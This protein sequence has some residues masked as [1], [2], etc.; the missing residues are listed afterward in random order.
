MNKIYVVFLVLLITTALKAQP[1]IDSITTD[2][3]K[4]ELLV[5]GKFHSQLPT[6][7]YVDSVALKINFYSD[8]LYK[9]QI[10][11]MGKGS[12]G[13]VWVT[14]QEKSSN[15][16]LLTFWH[17]YVKTSFNHSYSDGGYEGW[18]VED[19]VHFRMDVATPHLGRYTIQLTKLSTLH[20]FADGQN[21]IHGYFYNG[22]RYDRRGPLIGYLVYDPGNIFYFYD[23][24]SVKP[25]AADLHLDND[26]QILSV[27][28][29]CWGSSDCAIWTQIA[30]VDFPPSILDVQSKTYSHKDFSPV[31]YFDQNTLQSDVIVNAASSMKVEIELTDVIGRRS[32][33]KEM[34]LLEGKNYLHLN[35]IPL[36]DGVYLCKIKNQQEVQVIK[37]V[38]K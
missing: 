32:F 19:T 9:A 36:V 27:T 11:S 24:D 33:S 28:R 21:G 38:K 2:E 5:Y 10:P 13:I 18:L 30:S 35:N 25:I 12:A 3:T 34:Y 15:K 23:T 1:Y 20:T 6:L 31:I 14:T 26:Y 7:V 17:V 29:G 37:F 4:E 16:K 22:P 8:T